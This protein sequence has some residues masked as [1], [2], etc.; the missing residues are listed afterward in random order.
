MN[1]SGRFSRISAA[2]CATP[3]S[4]G[5]VSIR[6]QSAPSSRNASAIAAYAA[7]A[8]LPA[9]AGPMSAKTKASQGFAS[10]RAISIAA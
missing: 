8:S 4:E 5:S 2:V 3:S 9:G 7:A 6:K 1:A 10:A